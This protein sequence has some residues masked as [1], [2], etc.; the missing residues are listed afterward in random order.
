M[1]S[2]RQADDRYHGV[3]GYGEVFGLQGQ[4]EA[5][6]KILSKTLAWFTFLK[7]HIGC[8][9]GLWDITPE[10]TPVRRTM[11]VHRWE[12]DKWKSK[13]LEGYS[14]GIRFPKKTRSTEGKEIIK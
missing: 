6:G 10:R 12:F 14:F 8:C 4:G 3:S 2:R 5:I 1:K 13:E 11:A 9:N 7:D